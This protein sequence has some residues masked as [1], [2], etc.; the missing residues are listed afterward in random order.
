MMMIVLIMWLTL[1]LP[2]GALIGHCVLSEESDAK[3][4]ARQY[5]TARN[6]RLAKLDR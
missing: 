4:P 3:A 6:G 5:V 1:A 2:A